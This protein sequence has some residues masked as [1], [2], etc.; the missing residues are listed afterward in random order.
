[1]ELEAS[2]A[3]W[4]KAQEISQYFVFAD[5]A[6]VIDASSG[7]QK[8]QLLPFQ[9]GSALDL[10]V[11]A[12]TKQATSTCHVVSTAIEDMHPAT[13]LPKAFVPSW[14]DQMVSAPIVSYP[15]L[16]YPR[17]SCQ[18]AARAHQRTTV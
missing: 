12:V 2:E 16:S 1:M 9:L 10:L 4:L 13:P 17:L 3:F 8:F 18:P 6:Q 11:E 15:R 5:I 7:V 14:K